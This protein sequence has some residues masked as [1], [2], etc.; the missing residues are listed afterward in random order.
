MHPSFQCL[1]RQ[2]EVMF[3]FD[4][5]HIFRQLL[6]THIAK[7]VVLQKF[8]VDSHKYCIAFKN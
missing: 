8:V 1:K 6:T 5:E 3:V 4:D 7:L 2:H